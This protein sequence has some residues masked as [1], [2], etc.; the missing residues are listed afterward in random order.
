MTP[1]TKTSWAPASTTGGRIPAEAHTRQP[2]RI[3]EIAPD[4]GLE[5]VWALP[6]PGGPDDLRLLV[7]QFTR[8]GDETEFPAAY[9]LLMALRWKLGALLGL[10]REVTGIDHR[11]RSL[12]DRLPDDLRSEAGPEFESVPF[13][14]VYLTDREFAAEIAN[15][16]VHAVLHLGWVPDEAD[17]ADGKGRHHAQMAVLVRPNG[18]LG[19]AYLALIKP[20]RHL[21]VYPALL[22]TIARQWEQRGEREGARP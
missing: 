8:G 4:F 3:H 16:T 13:S 12:R 17:G 2:W 18:L 6:T 15:R 11:V 7:E 10:D 19:R 1:S 14:P 20:V 21:V 9:R 22:R 5:D